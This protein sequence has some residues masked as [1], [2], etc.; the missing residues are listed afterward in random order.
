[1]I[2]E[3]RPGLRED[4]HLD[5]ALKFRDCKAKRKKKKASFSEVTLD[6]YNLKF[7]CLR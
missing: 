1:M 2:S 5:V 6:R 7:S 3:S 4:S